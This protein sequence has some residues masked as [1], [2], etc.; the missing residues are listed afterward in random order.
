MRNAEDLKRILDRINGKGYKAY[1]DCSGIYDFG[2]YILYI[3][4]VQGDPFASPSKIRVRLLQTVAGFPANTYNN[5]SREVG[6]RD[7]ITREFSKAIKRFTRFRRGSGKSGIIAIDEPG[8]EILERS[9]CIIN[10]EWVEVRFVMGLPAFGRRISSKDAMAMFFEELPKIVNASLIYKNLNSEKLDL[11][12]KTNEDADYIRNFLEERD[13][14]SFIAD[15]SILPRASGIDPHPL[16]QGNV[17]PFKSPE[18]LKIKLELP[19]KGVVSGM[20]IPEGITL[21]VGGG[22]HGKSTLLKAVQFGVYNHIPGDG[23]ELVVTVGNAVKI[24][25]E[26]GRRIEK[27][28]ISPFI[29]NLP[30]GKD[31]VNFTTD[32]ASGSTSQA[33][34]IIE[35]LEIG[36]KL[37]IMDED[38]SATNFMIRDHRMQELV[39]KNKEPITPFIDKVKQLYVDYGVSTLLALGGSGDY[40]D[41]ANRVLCMTEYVPYDYTKKA[42]EIAKKYQTGRVLEGGE[43]FGTI[44]YRIPLKGSFD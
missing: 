44:K 31:T 12:I 39:S 37:L 14:V 10:S 20:G 2:K 9:S 40:F 35:A 19:N 34:N 3:D 1:K 23:R 26:D 24:R 17:V 16:K 30:F 33:A 5:K 38:T 21:I 22:Y 25:A 7:F 4:H 8:Q 11:H 32:D 41:V 13:L 18:A 28:D 6:L 36:T 43:K 27:V 29:K 15:G 42:L